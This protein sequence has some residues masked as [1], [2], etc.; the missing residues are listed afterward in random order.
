MREDL[1]A[2]TIDL[3]FGSS[4]VGCLEP[5]RAL[6]GRCQRALVRRPSRTWPSPCPAGL[7]A[8]FAT[9]LYDDVARAAVVAHKEEGR[10]SLA[11]PLGRALSWAVLA[12]LAEVPRSRITAVAVVPV[13]SARRT[14]R[15]R[16]HDPLLRMSRRAVVEL[17][18]AGVAAE[19]RP[20]LR[21]VRPVAD[22]GGLSAHAR[23]LNLEH[24]FAVRR[25][26]PA[27]P[28]VVVDD[29]MTTGAT[30]VEAARA[31]RE[32]GLD[33]IGSA[34]VAATARRLPHRFGDT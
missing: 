6:C 30:L 33:V 26:P 9:T 8:V 4:C 22:Q 21:V 10:L 20:C 5:G 32:C 12:A 34:V 28:V 14:V 2:A 1:A 25:R 15:D 11:Q 29:V 17:R 7:P 16:G 23:A 27:S 31:S 3:L 19:L 24:A 13:P 18:R